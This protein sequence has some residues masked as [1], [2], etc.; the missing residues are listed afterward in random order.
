MVV[1]LPVA[2]RLSPRRLGLLL[3]RLLRWRR[4]GGD[5]RD[6]HLVV[7]RRHHRGR[8]RLGGRP[9]LLRGAVQVVHLQFVAG[10]LLG[11][12]RWDL[13]LRRRGG[14]RGRSRRRR[15]FPGRG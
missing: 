12:V 2:G 5:D 14:S 13:S 9:F 3:R 7:R 4:S 8:G 15:R 6:A 11:N 1:V 10:E